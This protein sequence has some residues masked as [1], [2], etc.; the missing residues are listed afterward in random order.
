MG[1]LNTVNIV[2]PSLP[3]RLTNLV[4]RVGVEPTRRKTARRLQTACV[5]HFRHRPVSSVLQRRGRPRTVIPVVY[6]SLMSRHYASH[7]LGH[8]VMIVTASPIFA[9][10][11]SQYVLETEVQLS[12]ILGKSG[13]STTQLGI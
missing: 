13:H 9:L 4:G 3:P 7:L 12:S 1:T 6:R 8:G 10:C 11:L 5:Y 2:R